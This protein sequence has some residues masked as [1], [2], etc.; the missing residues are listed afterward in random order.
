MSRICHALAKG[1]ANSKLYF[2]LESCDGPPRASILDS[3]SARLTL[4]LRI[5]ERGF[6]QPWPEEVDSCQLIQQAS[7]GEGGFAKQPADFDGRGKFKYR[8]GHTA[9]RP[10]KLDIG[11]YSQS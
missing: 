9:Q 5:A 1:L 7:T 3:R 2:V 6:A 11:A 8:Q 10:A 4:T